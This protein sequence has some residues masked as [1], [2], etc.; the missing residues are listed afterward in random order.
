MLE[1][2][3]IR[4]QVAKSLSECLVDSKRA[5]P[6]NSFSVNIFI[7]CMFVCCLATQCCDCTVYLLQNVDKY[8]RDLC[9]DDMHL[10]HSTEFS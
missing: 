9:K 4:A 7:S 6:S 3:M 8:E 5:Q 2:V 10:V 1:H